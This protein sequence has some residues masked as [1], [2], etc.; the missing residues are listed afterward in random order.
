MKNGSIVIGDEPTLLGL[1]EGAPQISWGAN[2]S[3]V[4]PDKITIFQ[5]PIEARTPVRRTVIMHALERLWV[6]K[7]IKKCRTAHKCA[8]RIGRDAELALLTSSIVETEPVQ[9]VVSCII[10]L[11]TMSSEKPQDKA[12]NF[13]DTH[14]KSYVGFEREFAEIMARFLTKYLGSIWFL[15]TNIVFIFI[16]II[17]NL[18][19]IPG[20]H[21]FDPYPFSLLQMIVEFSAMFLAI[22]V[23]INQN[24]QGRMADIRQQID[25]EINVRA[26]NEITKILTMLDELH[27][28]LGIV[29]T[30][31]E[32]DKMK[33][34][35]DIA[36]IK[37]DIEQRIE[38]R[39]AGGDESQ[40]IESGIVHKSQNENSGPN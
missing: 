37:E 19:Y 10:S 1:Y 36:E 30:D 16:W 39:D 29:K 7:E 17:I 27:V 15:N 24:Q 6:C 18:G 14:L 40:T 12:N 20:V 23:L 33:E 2:C 9:S 26:E 5:K 31:K 34:K 21:P 32:L 25:L 35:I 22:V 4:P 11:Y 28:K 13:F 3:A 38:N 8:R